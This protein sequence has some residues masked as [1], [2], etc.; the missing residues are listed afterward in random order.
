MWNSTKIFSKNILKSQLA[1][2]DILP[3]KRILNTEFKTHP[4]NI[5]PQFAFSGAS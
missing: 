3:Q 5:I 4:Y 2:T 1:V